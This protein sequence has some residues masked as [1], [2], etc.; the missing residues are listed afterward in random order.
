MV[1]TRRSR[2]TAGDGNSIEQDAGLEGRSQQAEV[3]S[4]RTR[5]SVAA[6]VAH[7]VLE[8]VAEKPA[9]A[10]DVP[11][12]GVQE[13]MHHA[14]S[15]E[16]HSTQVGAEQQKQPQKQQ[17]QQQLQKVQERECA[18]P[19]KQQQQ[20]IQ[21]QQRQTLPTIVQPAADAP[22]HVD[23]YGADTE[24][25]NADWEFDGPDMLEN[26][27]ASIRSALGTAT[28]AHHHQQQQ[29][30]QKTAAGAAAA[31][32]SDDDLGPDSLRW[33]PATG[34]QLP[35][36]AGQ[37]M[38]SA[39][40]ALP[41]KQRQ[42]LAQTGPQVQ[43]PAHIAH[44]EAETAAKANTQAAAAEPTKPKGLAKHTRVPTLDP[45]AA[46][47]EARK[48]K[49]ETAGKKWY[50]L[51]AVKVTDEVK[52]D[53]RLLR[54]RGAYDP[55]RFYKS[56]DETRFPKHFAVSCRVHTKQVCSVMHK[57]SPGSLC[58]VQASMH[59]CIANTLSYCLWPSHNCQLSRHGIDHDP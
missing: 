37:L 40:A 21:K 5:K 1:S 34:L 58:G 23:G 25:E 56:F 45:A 50:D 13:Q 24:G 16:D 32:D 18:T 46:A 57:A 15:L 52:R 43:S 31:K 39:A 33:R 38:Q 12:A 3:S 47:K 59:R 11:G 51:P 19:T 20:P 27:A 36:K 53:L 4:R 41:P 17:G 2:S 7:A 9:A 6:V 10:A 8:P 48:L 44:A 55:K 42:E 29:T 22:R 26:L 28:G 49:P 30:R 54:L 14:Q 35:P